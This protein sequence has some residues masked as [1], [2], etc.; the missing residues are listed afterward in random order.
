MRRFWTIGYAIIA[1]LSYI[2][3]ASVIL[4]EVAT[5]IIM[6]PFR[7]VYATT[8]RHVERFAAVAYQMIRPLKP[9][10]RESWRTH[11]LSLTAGHPG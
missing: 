2:S 5:E 8:R 1:C 7:Q 4:Y 10:Y 9:E 6:T 11:G 3:R